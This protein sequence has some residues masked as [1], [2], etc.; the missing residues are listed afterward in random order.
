MNYVNANRSYDHNEST[1]LQVATKYGHIQVVNVLLAQQPALLQS[2]TTQRTKSQDN[3]MYLAIKS[4]SKKLV[5]LY[6]HYFM[7]AGCI[8]LENPISGLTS[9][10]LAALSNLQSL[11]LFLAEQCAADKDFRNRYGETSLHIAKRKKLHRAV[12]FL[13]KIGCRQDIENFDG[14][15]V[16]QIIM[17]EKKQFEQEVRKRGNGAPTLNISESKVLKKDVAGGSIN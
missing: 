3:M 4:K 9:F 10:M 6:A 1:A 16:N 13:Q 5:K 11:A 14:I 8:D 7:S 2:V 17:Y 15:T 12:I